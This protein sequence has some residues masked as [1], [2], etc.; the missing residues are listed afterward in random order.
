MDAETRR[1]LAGEIA[2]AEAHDLMD[3]PTITPA[4]A[5][6]ALAALEACEKTTPEAA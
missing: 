4:E 6:E 3:M 5:K 2:F 1:R